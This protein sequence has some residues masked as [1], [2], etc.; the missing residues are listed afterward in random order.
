MDEIEDIIEGIEFAARGHDDGKHRQAAQRLEQLA[1][2]FPDH[3]ARLLVAAGWHHE[4]VDDHEGA[5][6]AYRKAVAAGGQCEPDARCYLVDGLLQTGNR[7]EAF[8]LLDEIRRERPADPAVYEH[9]GE[10]LEAA[11]ELEASAR[12]FTMGVLR[13]IRDGDDDS[14]ETRQLMVGRR[15]VRQQLGLPPDDHDLQAE[16]EL[17]NRKL[18]LSRDRPVLVG[19]LHWPS[20]EFDRL[21]QLLPEVAEGYGGSWE[22]HRDQVEVDLRRYRAAGAGPLSVAVGE[23]EDYLS[24]C[25]DTGEPPAESS[26]R[27]SYAGALTREGRIRPWPPGRKSACWCGS[28]KRYKHCCAQLPD[29]D[30]PS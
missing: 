17:A 1:V 25:A 5:L 2:D 4:L 11:G 22:A 26:T 6:A 8:T 12:W 28:G 16:R 15:R 7:D 18:A 14:F 29:P 24:Y 19:L 3:A 21:A 9:L 20:A 10:S 23:V 13:G 30:G 27:A